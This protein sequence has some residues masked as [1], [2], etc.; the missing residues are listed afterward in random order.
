MKSSKRLKKLK[1]LAQLGQRL[2]AGT[3]KKLA[4]EFFAKFAE[5]VKAA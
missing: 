5:A 2:V 4:D 3:A 1:K